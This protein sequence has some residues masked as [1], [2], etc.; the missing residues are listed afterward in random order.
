LSAACKTA[1]GFDL[2][3]LEQLLLQLRFF[4]FSLLAVGDVPDKREQLLVLA[5]D[6]LH[7]HL[8]IE[9]ASVLPPVRRFEKGMLTGQNVL[10][11]GGHPFR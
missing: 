6:R 4:L 9:Q 1:Y 2:L 10:D 7:A 5:R 11:L 3:G 8:D